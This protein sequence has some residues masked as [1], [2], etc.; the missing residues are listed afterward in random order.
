MKKI[1]IFFV[2]LM[3]AILYAGTALTE[4]VR[5]ANTDYTERRYEKAIKGYEEAINQGFESSALYFNMG[6]AWFK[7]RDVPMAILY[8]EKAARLD[9]GDEDIRFNLELANTRIV[10]KIDAVPVLFFH[11]WWKEA[12][13]WYSPDGWA[14]MTIWVMSLFF[15]FAALY[16]LLRQRFLRKMFFG[17]SLLFLLATALSFT[18]AWKTYA[19][20]QQQK[21]AIIFSPAIH[22]K[23]SPDENSVD[24]F[25]VHEGTKVV[26]T[27][28]LGTW[29]KVV[30]ANGSVGW[31]PADALRII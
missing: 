12:Q 8:Y 25:V 31:I 3:P 10:D 11:R 20:R 19:I 1:L 27:D 16:L 2:M 29:Y 15:L 14:R 13:S 23:S 4:L 24:L 5:M 30:I 21:E 7:L 6:N 17:C 28:T 26:L 22:V 18:F 9:P